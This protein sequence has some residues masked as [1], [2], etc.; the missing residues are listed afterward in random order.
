MVRLQKGVDKSRSEDTK[1]LK[2]VV[3]DWLVKPGES[4]QPPIF[5]NNKQERGFNHHLT[6]KMLCPVNWDW[7]D[8]A[9]VEGLRS[10]ATK[11][12]GVHWP[13][14]L[15]ENHAY[16]P[17][18]PWK[19]L[20]R[21]SLLLKAYKHIFTSPSSVDLQEPKATRSG[22]AR[23][24][25]MFEAT[26]ASIAYVATQVRFAL[27]SHNVFSRSNCVTETEQFYNTCMDLFLDKREL[28]DTNALLLWWNRKVFPAGL[29]AQMPIPDDT[30]LARIRAKRDAEEAAAKLAAESSS[31]E[32]Q[33]K[34]SEGQEESS[35]ENAGSGQGDEGSATSNNA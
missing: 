20:F 12:L 14:F 30:P 22:N 2:G 33:E 24:H 21:G 7:N 15:Y 28:P 18:D 16:D 6:G 35:Q 29:S 27:S 34:R 23:I 1:G 10:G 17:S 8:P 9:V 11:I 25:G 5:R 31:V 26:L 3:I 32:G 19:G 4:V 13:L